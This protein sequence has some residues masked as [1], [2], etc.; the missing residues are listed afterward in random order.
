M[1]KYLLGFGAVAL[2]LGG[3]WFAVKNN[4]E[5]EVAQINDVVDNSSS[6]KEFTITTSNFKFS[7]SMMTVKK[8]DT[9]KITVKNMDG[10][11]D[12]VI[13]EF[14]VATKK[15]QAGQEETLTFIADKAGSFE[16]YCSVGSHRKMGMKGTLTVL[17]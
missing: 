4:G 10:F 6:V 11:H 15:L 7:E 12:F 5:A 13:D 14:G 1:N 16:F 8:G 2:V 17:E 9:V 3:T